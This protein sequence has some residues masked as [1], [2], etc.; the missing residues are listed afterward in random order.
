[1]YTIQLIYE[2]RYQYHSE[3]L[4]EFYYSFFF[5]FIV[6]QLGTNALLGCYNI[7]GDHR[8]PVVFE[9]ATNRPERWES[10]E[11]PLIDIVMASDTI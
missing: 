5:F 4:F 2:L 8:A 1:M 9:T 3:K 11:Q 10:G 6:N 7:K